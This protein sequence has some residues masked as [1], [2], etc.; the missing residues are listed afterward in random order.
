[1]HAYLSDVVSAAHRT[2]LLAEGALW[3]ETSRRGPY[4]RTPRVA[5][6]WGALVQHL[7]AGAAQPRAGAV[8]CPA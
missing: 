5:E 6:R 3:R 1:M 2:E 7:S 4:V 8:C